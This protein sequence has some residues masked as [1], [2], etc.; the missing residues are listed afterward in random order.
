M[1]AILLAPEIILISATLLIIV[2]GLFMEARSKRVLG[3]IS[4][5]ALFTALLT[6]IMFFNSSGTLLYDALVFDAASQFFKIVFLSVAILT[7]IT[8]LKYYDGHKAQ[9]EYY[10]LL[11]FATLGMMF[12]ASANDL[13]ALFVG[14]EL[15]SLS[16][17][18]LAGF[19]K[20]NRK[21][22][23]ASLKYFIIG[24]LSSAILLFGISYI[25]GLTGTTSIPGIAEA[26]TV[27][28]PAA[29]LATV[30]IIA[31]FGFKMALVP[32]HMWAPD[33]YEGAPTPVSAFLAAGSKKMAFIAA[34]RVLLVALMALRAEWYVVFAILAVIT[35]TFGN[36]VAI[37]QTSVKR[38]LAYSSVAQAGYIAM[39]FVVVGFTDVSD[40]A[41][42]ALAGGI[43][44]TLAHAFMKTGAFI[45]TAS[46]EEIARQDNRDPMT[47]DHLD[48]FK[49]LGKRAPFTAFAMLICVFALA[50]IPPTAGFL[51]KWVLFGSVVQAGI[52]GTSV[53]LWLIGLAVAAVLNSALSLYYYARLVK[54]MYVLKSDINGR[55]KQSPMYVIA[56][57][58]AVIFII[59]IGIHP[60]F[61]DAA[62]SASEALLPAISWRF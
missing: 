54:Y 59:G 37:S 62:M 43:L 4:L 35:M 23:E 33:T 55:A 34:F 32:F 44:Y 61:Y 21:S 53:H 14:F 15:A 38:M 28:S 49:G 16:T 46:V 18:V 30:F 8:S 12:V 11:L 57:A 6:T 22:T 7:V 2:L 36:I 19:D 25:Y 42:Y 27:S 40:V 52:A 58:I 48:N 41:Q 20:S 51:S 60:V 13:V 45:A 1:S 50:G 3:I 26:L 47:L 39:A 10:A 29:I 31:G 17:Y 9:D 24:S 5:V 56:L